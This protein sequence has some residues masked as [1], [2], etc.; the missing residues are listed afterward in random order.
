MADTPPPPKPAK[1][2]KPDAFNPLGLTDAARKIE[3][4]AW[5]TLRGARHT[6]ASPLSL[7]HRRS[8]TRP[9]STP[10]LTVEQLNELPRSDTPATLTRIDY[11]PGYHNTRTLT[12][13]DELQRPPPE[14]TVV[15]WINVD[16]LGNP[17]ILA[18]LARRYD[19]HPLAMEDVVNVGQRPKIEPYPN[20]DP[21]RLSLFIVCRMLRLEGEKL[22]TEQ[23]SFFVGPN[24]IITVQES[25]GDVWDAVR[26]RIAREGSRL[27]NANAP[28]LLYA[29]LDAIADA[30]F[31]VIEHYSDRLE[32]LEDRVVLNPDNDL[33]HQ[34]HGIKREL[35]LVRREV[36]PLRELLHQLTTSE[37]GLIDDTTRTYLRDVYDHGIQ[38]LEL[39][40]TARE[41]AASLADTWMNAMSTRMNEVMK[42][43]TIIA[44]LLLPASFLAGVFG[45][46]FEY[47]PLLNNPHGFW[48][49]LGICATSMLGLL[50]YFRWRKWI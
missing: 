40:E 38:A 6:L 18:G 22:I 2:S 36:W 20:S 28:F 42:V 39:I 48:I 12:D 30:L 5:R 3:R 34:I 15:R 29:L 37:D 24:A 41:V 10:G 11:G 25:P 4:A 14:G 31:P 43:L 21:H 16:G 9:G 27:R 46:N 45:M 23:V 35:M 19:L 13:P 49:F 1:S 7:H 8:V 17:A 44:S 26:Q 50:G 33:I 47:V 32:A